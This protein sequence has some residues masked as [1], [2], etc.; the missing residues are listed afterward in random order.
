MPGPVIHLASVHR[1][2]GECVAVESA[3]IELLPGEIHAIV[4]E[5][6]AGKSTLMKMAAGVF[7]PS[8]GRVLVDGAPLDPATPAEAIRRGI[9]MVH[10]HFMLVGAFRALENVILGSEPM[11]SGGR[12]DLDARAPA[13][14]P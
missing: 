5:N 2:F 3:E 1:R 10:Q 14:R 12:L 7:P 6:G 9:G 13:S 8:S 11:R 4:G